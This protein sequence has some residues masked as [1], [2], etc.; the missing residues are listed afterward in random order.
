MLQCSALLGDGIAEVW[1]AVVEFNAAV[2]GEIAVRRAE[3][4]R[5]WMWSEVT[6]ALVE[7]LRARPDVAAISAELEAAVIAGT[8]TPTA[9]AGAVL[10]AFLHPGGGERAAERAP[11]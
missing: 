10:R 9:A 7:E 8:M 2:A 4:A 3:Q 11:R 1:D 5:Q 6:D